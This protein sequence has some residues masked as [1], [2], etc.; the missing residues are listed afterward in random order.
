M[1]MASHSVKMMFV[2]G[3][4]FL[5]GALIHPGLG[6]RDTRLTEATL[7]A[8]AGANPAYAYYDPGDICGAATTADDDEE[9]GSG[10]CPG[11]P[12]LVCVTCEGV[13]SYSGRAADPFDPSSGPSVQPGPGAPISC[14]E[15]TQRIGI[16]RN[17]NGQTYV[18]YY[19]DFIEWTWDPCTGSYNGFD[20]QAESS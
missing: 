15:L 14:A 2:G 9:V 5:L 13:I 4:L 6:V 3:T 11:N 8:V 12:N 17:H 19:C 7:R 10:Q 1:Q 16:C 18:P 20:L